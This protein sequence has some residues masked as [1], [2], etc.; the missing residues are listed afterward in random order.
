MIRWGLYAVPAGV[1]DGTLVSGPSEWTMHSA[2]MPVKDY[3]K[4]AKSFN[5]VKFDTD[6]WA[7]LAKS[8]GVK[9]VVITAKHHDG[10]CLFDGD[11]TDYTVVKATLYGRDILGELSRVVKKQGLKMGFYYS[12]TLDWHHPNGT[13]NEWDFDPKKKNFAAYFNEYAMPQ[14]GELIDKYD[15]DLLCFDMPMPTYEMAFQ[16]RQY[17][18]KKSV[19]S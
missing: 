11:L 13:G 10:F 3:E 2:R 14:V 15:P 5:P 17:I 7:Q 8:F 18:Y 9:Y 12:Q 1:W 6:Q 16:L 19:L 4:L